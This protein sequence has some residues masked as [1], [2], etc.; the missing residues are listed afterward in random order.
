MMEIEARVDVSAAAAAAADRRDNGSVLAEPSTQNRSQKE[1][2]GI[3]MQ[4]K[5]ESLAF[6][7]FFFFFFYLVLGQCWH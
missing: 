3:H 4:G 5:G 2:H 7:F 6:F 1:E